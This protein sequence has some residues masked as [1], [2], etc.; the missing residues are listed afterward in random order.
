MIAGLL[1][2]GDFRSRGIP[3]PS[4]EPLSRS[5]ITF[6][7]DI[8]NDVMT[9]W[10]RR[11][12]VC[13]I[14]APSGMGR[15]LRFEWYEANIAAVMSQLRQFGVPIDGLLQIADTFRASIAWAKSYGLT[16]RN[17]V[18]ALWQTFIVHAFHER[19]EIDDDQ[20]AEDLARWS[21]ERAG[22]S[23]ITP[24]IQ[25]IHA[26]MP[27]AEFREHLDAYL[28]IMRQHETGDRRG[29]YQPDMSYFWRAGDRWKFWH[30]EG[31]PVEA[32]RDGAL[33]TIAVDVWTVLFDVW[34]R[35]EV[36]S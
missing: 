19:G 33:A 10:V 35:P 12:L 1:T 29:Q 24:R 31:G 30:G 25:A 21:E 8:P 4:L 23:R 11:G 13:P 6:R 14:E 34:N 27:K 36:S 2:G 17:D 20:L 22:A 5:G 9:F 15:H 28:T 16:N 3:V 32:Q 18:T 26:S 7:A